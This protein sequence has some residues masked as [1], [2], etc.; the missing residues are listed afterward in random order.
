MKKY[1]PPGIRLLR[2]CGMALDE[3]W[4]MP[5]LR[6]LA[7]LSEAEPHD[8]DTRH[9]VDLSRQAD[10]ERDVEQQLQEVTK[11]E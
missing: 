5:T 11:L 1:V 4:A 7:H 3:W 6:R 9:G 10:W 2:Y 8:K